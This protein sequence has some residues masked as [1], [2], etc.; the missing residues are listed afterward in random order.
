MNFEDRESLYP[1]RFYVT[2]SNGDRF[3][4]T[5][6]R[7]DSPVKP[8]TP[9][10]AATFNAMV[11]SVTARNLL[12]NTNFAAPVNQRGGSVYSGAAQYTIDRWKSTAKLDVSVDDGYLTVSCAKDATARNGLSQYIAPEK[13]PE[14]GT[15]ITVAYEDGS[16]NVYVDS[17]VIPESGTLSL[18]GSSGV[19]VNYYGTEHPARISIMVPPDT[20]ADFL[21][22]ALYEGEFNKDTVPE[23][24]P[25]DYAAELMECMR[26]YQLRSTGDIKAVDL[27]PTM[28][29]DP[30]ITKAGGNY[31]YS[32]DF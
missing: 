9:L 15:A 12:D 5:L 22:I 13:T 16:G 14:P 10:N 21:W 27:R 17:G 28:R 3:Y 32:A 20:T 7:A 11:R 18:F 2:D 23:Y 30:T 29:D 1:G 26:Y 31:A 4:L 25:K 6:Q 24:Q 8:G 19:G